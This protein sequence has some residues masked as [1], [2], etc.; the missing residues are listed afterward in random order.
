MLPGRLSR[1]D[2]GLQND[3][4]RR[5]HYRLKAPGANRVGERGP[6]R[7]TTR[8]QRASDR[9]A[10]GRPRTRVTQRKHLKAKS[11][12]C[13]PARAFFSTTSSPPLRVARATK[14]ATASSHRTSST[15]RSSNSCCRGR[16]PSKSSTRLHLKKRKVKV[17]IS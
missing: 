9:V 11:D 17:K 16:T 8:G 2:Q 5:P 7:F 6:L 1:A 13:S 14:W 12:E 3:H 4:S 15:Q 10:A